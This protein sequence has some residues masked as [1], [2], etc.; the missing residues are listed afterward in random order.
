MS[1]QQVNTSNAATPVGAYPH[2]LKAGPFL[3]LSGIGPRSAADNSIPGLE[4]DSKGNF[5]SFDFEAQVH[6]VMANIKAVLEASGAQWEQLVDITVY[7]VN[8]ERDF[9]TFN[10]IYATYFADDHK[11]CRTT[12]AVNALPTPIAIELKCIAYIP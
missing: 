12:V 7:L 1:T 6:S 11:P 2:A 5:V 9:N 3:F 4:I 8:M 10:K